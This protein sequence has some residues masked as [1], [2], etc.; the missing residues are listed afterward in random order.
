MV[1][2][3][4]IEAYLDAAFFFFLPRPP[5]C[6]VFLARAGFEATTRAEFPIADLPSDRPDGRGL[7]HVD[8]GPTN[9]D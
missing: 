3:A 6:S 7:L 8:D 9:G 1:R 2:S 4:P 5:P